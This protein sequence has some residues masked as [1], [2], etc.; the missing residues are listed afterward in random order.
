MKVEF[1]FYND[2]ISGYNEIWKEQIDKV[3]CSLRGTVHGKIINLPC[4][5]TKE[6]EIELS[7][8]EELYNFTEE[9]MEWLDD[10]A[11][12]SIKLIR[13][14]PTHLEVWLYNINDDTE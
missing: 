8:F 6:M 12:Y 14:K 11:I 9:E 13:I 7:T 1:V 2:P 3:N 5:P 10:C 4:I